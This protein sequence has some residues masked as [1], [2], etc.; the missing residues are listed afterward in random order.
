MVAKMK[1][2]IFPV[3]GVA[4][5]GADSEPTGGGKFSATHPAQGEGRGCSG[6]GG[7]LEVVGGVF[8]SLSG[9][10][11]WAEEVAFEPEEKVY[12][13]DSEESARGNT[14]QS[15][16]E[17]ERKRRGRVATSQGVVRESF[18]LTIE[19]SPASR[20][21]SHSRFS[22]TTSCSSYSHPLVRTWHVR[23]MSS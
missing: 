22:L 8:R 21:P 3:N 4:L 10:S 7:D 19:R 18:T 12:V 14:W 13:A 6:S 2:D 20:P 9:G 11:R 1:G 5:N 23:T 17:E 16:D 15:V